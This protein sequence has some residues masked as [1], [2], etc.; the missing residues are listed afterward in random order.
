MA[1]VQHKGPLRLTRYLSIGAADAI[2]DK[3]YL[4]SC[5]L[6]NGSAGILTD[7]DD[8]KCIALGRTGAGKTALLEI[9]DSGHERTIKLDPSALAIS[10]LTNNEI[11]K[12]FSDAGVK[13]DLFYRLLW[14]HVLVIEIIKSHF[15]IINEQT[16]ESFFKRMWDNVTIG[17]SKKEALDYV[18]QWG[19]SFWESTD[20]R[21]KEVTQ[22]FE[23]DLKSA[24]DLSLKEKNTDS[25]IS[26]SHSRGKKLSTEE[27]AEVVRIGQEVVNAVQIQRMSEVINLL[28]TD[29]L[30]DPQ[31]RYYITIDKLDEDWIE[32]SLRYQM[33]QALL[34]TIKDMNIK[35]R[36]IKVIAAIRDDL[37]ARTFRMTR[38]PG[39]QSDK[40]KSM[41]LSVTWNAD[42]L[43]SLINMRLSAM[44]E[45]Q[46]TSKPVTLREILPERTEKVDYVE[47]FLNRTLMRPRDA[48]MLLNECIKQSEGKKRMTKETL[49]AAEAIYSNNRLDAL[50][51][52]WAADYPYLREYALLLTQMPKN[53]KV[54]E[55]KSK[56]EERCVDYFASKG[57]GEADLLHALAFKKYD[58]NEYNLTFDLVAVLFKAG[59]I[60]LKKFKGQHVRWSFQGEEFLE[61]EIGEETYIEIHPAFYKVLGIA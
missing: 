31:K 20:Y 29:I 43:E 8:P 36:N 41:Y 61:S 13:M 1:K 9:I 52:E 2:Q 5:F 55:K 40:Y 53:F 47:Y 54:F 24:F 18:L 45:R 50:S 7:M 15:K 35:I 19:R 10:Y 37:V 28:D 11:I 34:E 42:E 16:R 48:I 39:Y 12:F 32:D 27:K 57:N 17:R 56:I 26:I 14:R 22:N 23:N 4:E 3:M 60:G 33:L 25:N 59:V 44:I 6:D 21:V 49:S 38:N 51:D 46:F 58:S 30:T